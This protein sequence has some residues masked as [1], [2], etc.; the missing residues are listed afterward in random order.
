MA[1][2]V[3]I[4]GGAG[5]VGSQL[6]LGLAE[7]HP[8]WQITAF[9]NLRRRGSELNLFRLQKAGIRFV[10]G[11]VRNRDDLDPSALAPDLILECSAEPSV[12]AGYAAPLYLLQTNLLGTVHCLEL[13]RTT[14]ADFVFLSTSRV[15]PIAGLRNLRY[16]ET[17][18]RLQLAGEQNLPGA[19]KHGIAEGFGLE[20]VR[21]LYGA[22]KLASE[23]VVGEYA[24]AY[25]LRT[26]VNRCG[27]LT[28]PWQ[29]GKVDQGVFALWMAAHYFGLPLRYIGFGGSGKQVRDFLHI[30]DLLELIDRQIQ[31]LEQLQGRTFNVGG[32]VERSLSLLE[33]TALCRQIT[34]RTASILSVAEERPGDVPVFI[35]DARRAMAETGWQPERDAQSTLQEIYEWIARH[36]AQ[37]KPIL[38]GG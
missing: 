13:A 23:L 5:F 17:A 30:A 37:L 29:M 31:Q 12:L 6:G 2:R 25:G 8:D 36:E 28:G 1:R 27:V 34:G 9:D 15:Y 18:T 10:H 38:T 3:L 26:L 14:G 11:D 16:T 20:G 32:G 7:R 24:D 4:T 35:T 19:S 22:S 21:S 33:T